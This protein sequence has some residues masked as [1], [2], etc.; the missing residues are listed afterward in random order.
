MDSGIAFIVYSNNCLAIQNSSNLEID[1]HL[2]TLIS[3]EGSIYLPSL[4]GI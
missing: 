2:N 4:K 1:S 3:K